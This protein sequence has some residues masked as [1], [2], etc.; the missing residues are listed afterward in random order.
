M[1]TQYTEFLQDD[2]RRSQRCSF[3]N[4]TEVISEILVLQPLVLCP[5]L[6]LFI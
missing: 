6:F 4:Q 5:L 1:E 3:L 2:K